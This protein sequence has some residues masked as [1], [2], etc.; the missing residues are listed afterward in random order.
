[1]AGVKGMRAS[2][3][4]TVPDSAGPQSNLL[5]LVDGRSTPAKLIRFTYS[6]ICR[7][8]GGEDALSFAQRSLVLRASNLEILISHREAQAL[9]SG[10][11]MDGQALRDH[12]YAVQQLSALYA[13]LGLKRVAKQKGLAHVLGR[14][15]T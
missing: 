8:L 9:A 13:R 6:A 12:L 11:V 15:E 14:G 4:T 7:D 5:D 3:P 1:M 2:L 10:A